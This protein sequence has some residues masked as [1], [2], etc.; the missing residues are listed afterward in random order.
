MGDEEQLMMQEDDGSTTKQEKA[1]PIKSKPSQ[2]PVEADFLNAMPTWMMVLTA[3][4]VVAPLFARYYLNSRA[5]DGADINKT[6]QRPMKCPWPDC[7]MVLP[8]FALDSHMKN[9]DE[10]LVKHK[11]YQ[12][13]VKWKDLA[14]HKLNC[15]PCG[16]A[17]ISADEAKAKV[18][19][20]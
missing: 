17:G 3:I 14:E 16:E 20:I 7:K 12:C 11:P 5:N 13:E 15:P 6:R 18:E 8:A 1:E 9:C 19:E 2:K 10:R 4:L